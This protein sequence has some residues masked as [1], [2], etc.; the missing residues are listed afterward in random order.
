MLGQK[1]RRSLTHHANT[2]T[3]DHAFQGQYL[4]ILDLVQNVLCG[5]IS[6]ALEAEQISL[7]KLVNVGNVL[8]EPALGKLIYQRVSHAVD[9]HYSTRSKMQ[10]GLPQFGW[11]VRIDAAE[12]YLTFGLHNIG[13][14]HRTLVRHFKFFK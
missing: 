6:H 9:I 10:D 2:E 5:F 11:T 7:G 3:V 14:T 12:I 1:L 13:Y 4:R 8:H